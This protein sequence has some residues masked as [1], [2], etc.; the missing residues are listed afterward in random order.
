MNL[1]LFVGAFPPMAYGEIHLPTGALAGSLFGNLYKAVRHI[2]CLRVLRIHATGVTRYTQGVLAPATS[3]SAAL[4]PAVPTPLPH[5]PRA[6]GSVA[7]HGSSPALTTTRSSQE[8]ARALGRAGPTQPHR[9]RGVTQA[10]RRGFPRE[11]QL[12]IP[13]L[14]YATHVPRCSQRLT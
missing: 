7:H 10:A 2:P 11:A 4:G 5:R 6:G 3:T 1:L 14:T 8:V 12:C 13:A 9:S